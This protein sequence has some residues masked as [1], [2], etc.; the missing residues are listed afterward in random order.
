M[1]SVRLFR[2]LPRGESEAVIGTLADLLGELARVE[3]GKLAHS[4]IKH[5]T[6]IGG[7]YEGLTRELLVRSLPDGLDLQVVSGLVI[8]GRGGTSGQIDCMLV[9]GTGT[10]VPF[11][12]GIYQWHAK[13]VI[14]VFE[15]KKNLFGGDL[16]DAYLHLREVLATY[17]GWLQ[18]ASGQATVNL[19]PTLRAYAQTVCEVAPPSEQWRSMP[20]DKHLIL[21]T[22]M[23]DQLAPLR[24]IFGYE[25]YT[26]ERGL[27]TGFL[28]YLKENLKT[29]GFGP[30]SLPNLIVANH[31]SLVKLSG[32]PYQAQRKPNGRWPIMASSHLNPLLLVLELIWTRLSYEHP[33]APLFGEDLEV[34]ALAPLLDALPVESAE[35]ASGW[36]WQY[37]TYDLTKAQLAT[38]PDRQAWSPVEL[39]ANQFVVVNRLCQEDVDAE[40]PAFREF[41]AQEGLE[42]DTFVRG[43][44]GTSLVA[45]NGTKLTL[46]TVNCTCLLLPDGRRIAA[47]NNTGRLERWVD[48]FMNERRECSATSDGEKT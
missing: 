1:F 26:T 29:I 9:R 16:S 3:A 8:D 5:P 42:V 32:H 11:S 21:H 39:D 25:G 18:A 36:G 34:E 45:R 33:M 6:L 27:R 40:D 22:M 24:I 28:K 17:S 23:A 46:T 31:A 20:M 7:M 12:P 35:S 43:L 15:V 44:I 19:Q 48:R 47:D 37:Y 38:G 41:L 14:A 30:P 2:L 4:D 13:D 10:Q